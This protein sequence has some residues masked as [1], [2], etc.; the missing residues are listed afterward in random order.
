MSEQDEQDQAARSSMGGKPPESP[1][2]Q[3]EKDVKQ[4]RVDAG[5]SPD[6][7][8]ELL[9]AAD[10]LVPAADDEQGAE[11]ESTVLNWLLG[12][13]EALE[14][15]VEAFLDTPTGRQKLVFHIKQ[16]PDSRIS[17]LEKEHT[18]GEG[19]F[20]TVDR[21]QLN[22]AKVAEATVYIED[23]DGRQVD[24]GSK[25]FRGQVPA[26]V[27][28]VRGRFRFQPGIIQQVAQEV[29]VIAGMTTDRVNK[30]KR[31][32]AK[33]KSQAQTITAAVGNS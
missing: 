26:A 28:A 20:G 2:T 24:L 15:D 5:V 31:A 18:E 8:D 6:A 12:P 30:A 10:G 17:E 7:P 29:D 21:A 14:Y 25:E 27:D 33:Q 11:A 16:L 22:A 9:E 4:A 32:A 23:R 1:E 13:T 19:P 3:H